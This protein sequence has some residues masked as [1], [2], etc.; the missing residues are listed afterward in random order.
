MTQSGQGPESER[1]AHE[2]VVLPA[3]GGQ[4]LL[5]GQGADPSSYGQGAE[6][7]L[8]GQGA[9]DP[10]VPAGGQPWGEPWGPEPTPAAGQAWGAPEVPGAAAGAGGPGSPGGTGG[11]GMDA[12]ATQYISPVQAQAQAHAQPPFPPQQHAQPQAHA[13]GQPQLQP[14]P[15][16]QMQPDPHAQPPLPPQQH[17]Q[18]QHAQPSVDE[19]ATQMI[20]PVM[21]GPGAPG[22]PLP[23]Q[24]PPGALPPEQS[25]ESTYILG[26][27]A[28]QPPVP[29]TAPVAPVAPDAQ[30]T[31]YLPPVPPA[32]TGA[33]YGIRPGAPEDRQPPAEFDSLFRSEPADST[34]QMPRF[35]E[36]SRPRAASHQAPAGGR[37]AARRGAGG[38]GGNGPS[39]NQILAVV[40][41]G[42]A[43][44]GI[45]AG[46]LIGLLGGDDDG[47]EKD[48]E[49]AAATAPAEKSSSAPPAV[50]PAKTQAQALDKLL[51]D[52]N[53]SRDAVIR[54]V[55]AIKT[56]KN[57]GQAATD[58]RDA[59]RQR[60]SLVTRLAQLKTDKLPQQQQLR[61]ALN[62]AW[63]ASA[64]A[65]NHYAAWADQVG[66]KKGCPKGQ[67]RA[68]NQTRAAN[69]ASG[70]A[71]NAKNEAAPLWNEIAEQWGLPNR[72][73]QQL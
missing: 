6:P 7:L 67:A 48:P 30:A 38:G 33:P 73:P 36:P 42:I 44:V 19:A 58:L 43:V 13:H 35:E 18:P 2:G 64:S 3:D 68:T 61:D 8:P 31:Q 34:Q 69:K 57:L 32:P 1:P 37:A 59:A 27:Q 70:D 5:P 28:A 65:D 45:A 15:Q 51:A 41:V 29:P 54:S 47:G 60:T 46:G 72:T 52:S 22:V 20:P 71:T 26:G 56:C 14:Q 24:T 49:P 50:D 39:R 9:A 12:D 55:E 17:A 40:G 63:K 53:N 66:Q 10:A 11:P 16:P 23:P 25:A 4:P 62:K 21:G